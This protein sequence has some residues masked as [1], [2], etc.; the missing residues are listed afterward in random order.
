MPA[1]AMADVHVAI[2]KLTQISGIA[3]AG[4]TLTM[5]NSQGRVAVTIYKTQH[6]GHRLLLQKPLACSWE[7]HPEV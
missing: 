1:L 3:A 4:W 7:I 5:G 6:E 2:S